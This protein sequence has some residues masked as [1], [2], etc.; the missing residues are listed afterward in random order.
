MA[1]ITDHSYDHLTIIV[2]HNEFTVECRYINSSWFNGTIFCK[3]D[4]GYG[5]AVRWNRSELPTKKDIEF[6]ESI[7]NFPT[8]KE[9]KRRESFRYVFKEI[10]TFI[11]FYF[12]WQHHNSNKQW[13]RTIK[14]DDKNVYEKP[15]YEDRPEW[16]KKFPIVKATCKCD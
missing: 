16:M 10:Q 12:G 9:I 6:V 3:D 14:R 4:R 11:K 15:Q 13:V 2:K 1:I 5:Q 8:N 7:C